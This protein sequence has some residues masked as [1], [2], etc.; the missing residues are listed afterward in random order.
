MAW[1]ARAEDGGQ[2]G[3][4]LFGGNREGGKRIHKT[5]WFG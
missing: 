2:G 1:Q 4:G 3:A 5:V